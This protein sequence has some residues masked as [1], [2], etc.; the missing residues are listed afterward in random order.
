MLCDN[1]RTIAQAKEPRSHHKSKH[2]LRC[3]HLIKKIISRGDEVVERVSS[4][5]NVANPLTKPLAQ[6]VFERHCTTMGLMHK[7]AWL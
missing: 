7:G 1:N 5:D 2:I 3:F 6:E 4:T